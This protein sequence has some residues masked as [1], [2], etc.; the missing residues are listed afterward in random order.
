[1]P[2]AKV[3]LR[4]NEHEKKLGR[5][6]LDQARKHKGKFPYRMN[7]AAHALGYR[8]GYN[9][10]PEQVRQFISSVGGKVSGVVK[11]KKKEKNSRFITSE[12]WLEDLLANKSLQH[13]LHP[14]D[15]ENVIEWLHSMH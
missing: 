1:V 4:L 14:E 15:E 6:L 13:G 11:K 9:E 12:Q 8:S 7:L 3:V 5:A 2:K 10:V